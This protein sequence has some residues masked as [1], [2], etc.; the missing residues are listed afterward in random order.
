MSRIIRVFP[1][2]TKASPDDDLAYFG[3]PTFFAEADEVHVSVTFT[4]DKA[5][6]EGLAEQ[7]RHVAPVKV[8][9][10]AYGDTSLEFI[11]GR[12]IKPGYTITSRGC[13]RR[14]WFCGVWKKWPEPNVMPIHDGWNVLDDNLLACPRPHV[15][16]VFDM[17]RRQNRRVEFTGGL[18]ALSLQDYQVA[19]LASLKPRPNMF[20]AYDPGDEFE[21]LRSA[22]SRLLEAGFTTASHRMR[23]YVL[24][25]YPKDTFD[26]A[27]ARLLSMVKIGFTPH[28]MLWQP[29][30]PAAEKHRPA[31][32]WR[33]FQRRWA[34][35]AIIHSTPDL[36]A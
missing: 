16:A 18:E 21:T 7:W 19:L 8:G 3:P 5:I 1:R 32:E 27:E 33:A 23:V 2:R 36:A 30:T 13:P 10:V 20:F 11:P 28:A 29:E 12:Y 14:C 34:R 9:G 35:P 26:L 22:A 15:E 25:G 24:I 6:A 31:P 17:L 4:A